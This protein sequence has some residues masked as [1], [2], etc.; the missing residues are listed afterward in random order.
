[1]KYYR[2]EWTKKVKK[3]KGPNKGKVVLERCVYETKSHT[4][5]HKHIIETC[6]GAV[7]LECDPSVKWPFGV[8]SEVIAMNKQKGGE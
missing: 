2:T 5:L 6:A 1:M 8:Y 3:R 7:T 4:D